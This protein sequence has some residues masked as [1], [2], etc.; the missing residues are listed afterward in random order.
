MSALARASSGDLIIEGTLQGLTDV[1]EQIGNRWNH[2]HEERDQAQ[3]WVNETCD[4]INTFVPTLS[5]LIPKHDANELP[6]Y[7]FDKQLYER[8]SGFFLSLLHTSGPGRQ[9]WEP[10]QLPVLTSDISLNDHAKDSA[11]SYFM[12]RV[13]LDRIEQVYYKHMHVQ[14]LSHRQT[15]LRNHNLGDAATAEIELLKDYVRVARFTGLSGYLVVLDTAI[16]ADWYYYDVDKQRRILYELQLSF[17]ALKTALLVPISSAREACEL[18]LL[19]LK[20]IIA[21]NAH[22]AVN[23][24]GTPPT[25]YLPELG[26]I[27]HAH[28]NSLVA[29]HAH[30]FAR[31]LSKRRKLV[32]GS[33]L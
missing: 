19:T 20:R 7:I 18:L 26:H 17:Q 13:S 12:V 24:N 32:Y 6:T 14:E 8:T 10:R 15:L 11:Y 2:P 27:F 30:S 33:P 16:T 29:Q 22:Y 3:Q 9:C 21:E 28:R 5:R 31:P 1:V 25:P 23:P 4:F